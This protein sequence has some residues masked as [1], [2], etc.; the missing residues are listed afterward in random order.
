[1]MSAD[2]S[3]RDAFRKATQIYPNA[4]TLIHAARLKRK[5]S[6]WLAFVQA[7]TKDFDVSNL[8][9]KDSDD[10][11][12]ELAVLEHK[13]FPDLHSVSV[14]DRGIIYNIVQPKNDFLQRAAAGKGTLIN[15]LD[16]S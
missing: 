16:L 12:K 2:I 9:L 1:M 7:R 8:N 5:P 14:G 13:R 4:E 3:K 11:K 6:V 15:S 10:L